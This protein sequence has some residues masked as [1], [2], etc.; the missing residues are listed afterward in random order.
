MGSCDKMETRF[1]G[2]SR[3]AFQLGK[4]PPE[5]WTPLHRWKAHSVTDPHRFSNAL[6]EDLELFNAILEV[7]GIKMAPSNPSFT[8]LL[9]SFT[10]FRYAFFEFEHM[11]G[12]S[13][14]PSQ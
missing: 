7:S 1:K 11:Y 9:L 3:G 5:D 12:S 6:L 2:V 13:Y 8:Y 4:R 14:P 10:L